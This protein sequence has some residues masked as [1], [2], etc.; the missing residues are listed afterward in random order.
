MKELVD[1]I[2]ILWKEEGRSDAGAGSKDKESLSVLLDDLSVVLGDE[3]FMIRCEEVLSNT[4]DSD[5]IYSVTEED[6]ESEPNRYIVPRAVDWEF[7]CRREGEAKTT[8][9]NAE[10][11]AS[12]DENTDLKWIVN[13]VRKDTE[14]KGNKIYVSEYKSIPERIRNMMYEH[15][16]SLIREGKVAVVMLSGGDGSRLGYSGPKGTY[17]I[18]KISK[19][20]FF[21]IFCYKLRSLS[22]LVNR[23]YTVPLYIM[24]ST[25]NDEKIRDYFEENSYFGIERGKVTF[26]KQD[27]VPSINLDNKSFFLESKY[28]LLKSPNGNGGVFGSML[29]KGIIDDME[30]RGVKYIFTHCIDNPLC[31]VC[32]PL[33]VGYTDL[34]HLQVSTKTVVKKNKS[35]KIGT[36][37]E[38]HS[39]NSNSYVPKIIEYSEISGLKNCDEFKYGSVGIHIFSLEYVKYI[40][41]KDKLDYHTAVK[42]IKHYDVNNHTTVSPLNNN[43]VKLEMFIFDSFEFVTVPIHCINVERNEFSPVKSNQGDNSPANCQYAI[44]DLNKSFIQ[45]YSPESNSKNFSAIYLEISPLVTYF[46]ENLQMFSEVCSLRGRYIYINDN[47]EVECYDEV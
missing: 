19:D 36:V 24:T 16:L 31:K 21:K 32:D 11:C 9:R 41:N 35:E 37:L 26:F 13:E 33:F 29:K 25:N 38:K 2:D 3:K 39:K 23:E 1:Y 7:Y 42:K 46:G 30:K 43:G 18:G 14:A 28:R 17:P 12:C 5:R 15:G 47:S 20:S 8:C 40:S 22:R 6:K 10:K 44:S 45:K 34:L 4:C 27:S